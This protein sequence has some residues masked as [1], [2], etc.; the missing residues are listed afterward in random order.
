MSLMQW[1]HDLESAGMVPVLLKNWKVI[2]AP[3]S[4]CHKVEV[5]F[6]LFVVAEVTQKCLIFMQNSYLFV[7]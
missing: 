2:P 1:E 4:W 7:K 3:W 6:I 5:D